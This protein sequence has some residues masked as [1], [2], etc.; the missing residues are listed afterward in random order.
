MI[1][2]KFAHYTLQAVTIQIPN[3]KLQCWW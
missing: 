2:Y 1:T 3:V